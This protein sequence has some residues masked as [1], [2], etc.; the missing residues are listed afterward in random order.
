VAAP[1]LARSRQGFP[2][3][4]CPPVALQLQG[5]ILLDGSPSPRRD[6]CS[7]RSFCHLP[8]GLMSRSLSCKPRSE[9]SSG[10]TSGKSLQFLHAAAPPLIGAPSAVTSEC[11]DDD[12]GRTE[13]SSALKPCQRRFT[14]KNLG[15]A[16]PHVV[17]GDAD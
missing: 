11:G 8:L 12:D 14:H 13:G 10:A 4:P 15:Q 2:G 6:L 17:T 9:P 7:S 1:V 5:R 16:D 3:L